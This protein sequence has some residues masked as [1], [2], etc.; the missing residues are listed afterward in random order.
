VRNLN[1]GRNYG[2]TTEMIFAR[3]II[4]HDQEHPSYLLLPV[5]RA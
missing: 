4:H 5:I 2:T 3:Q 1:T